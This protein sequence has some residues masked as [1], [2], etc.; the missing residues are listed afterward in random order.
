MEASK[1]QLICLISALLAVFLGQYRKEY[2]MLAAL[3]GGAVAA[4]MLLGIIA[5]MICRLYNLSSG[6]T[7]SEFY[8]TA[9]KALGIAYITT[10][11][12]NTCRDAGQTALAA[13]AE[14]AG[15]CAI[16]ALALPLLEAVL[17]LALEF[18]KI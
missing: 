14:L 15:R 8:K 1:I 17:K 7:V 16:F 13:K 6:S 5:P 10:F 3:S 11:A 2:A 9:L 4:V 18:T 12:A